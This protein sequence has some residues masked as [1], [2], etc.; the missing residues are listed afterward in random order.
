MALTSPPTRSTAAGMTA[1]VVTGAGRGIGRAIALRLAR[2]GA[3]VALQSRT[4]AEIAET[5]ALIE[6]EGGRAIV[7]PGDVTEQA[8]AEALVSRAE[9]E[10]GS[11]SIA[12]AC[13][14]QALSAPILKTSGADLVRLFE[15]NVLSA[16]HLL[17]AA[18][19]RMIETSVHGRIVLVGSTA[20]V[21]GARYTAAYSASKHGLLGLAR[22]AA[23]ELAPKGITVNVLCPGWVDTSMFDRTLSNICEKTK[24]TTAEA[25]AQIEKTIPTGAVLTPE[26]V[27][28]A[29]AFLVSPLAAQVTGQAIVLDGGSTL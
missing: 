14:G 19:G 23:L 5:R 25:R 4:E 8:A 2:S 26:E 17:K 11:V 29:A 27:A 7:V 6:A 24:A 18:A 21:K 16:L 13:A 15:V 22:S 1:A 3:P 9:A 10:L 20:S 12:I 28:E